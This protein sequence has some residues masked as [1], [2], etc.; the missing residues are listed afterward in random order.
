V[1]G[2]PARRWLIDLEQASFAYPY[3]RMR[4]CRIVT[5]NWASEIPN[6][7]ITRHGMEPPCRVNSIPLDNGLPAKVWGAAK[8]EFPSASAGSGHADPCPSPSSAPAFPIIS[9]MGPVHREA[10][11]WIDGDGVSSETWLDEWQTSLTMATALHQSGSPPKAAS[12]DPRIAEL[13]ELS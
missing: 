8:S 1:R 7:W 12:P 10:T 2:S 6:S 3:Y 13:K 4:T 9:R 5:S 11:D